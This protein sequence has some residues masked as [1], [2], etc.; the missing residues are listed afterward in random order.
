MGDEQEFRSVKTV[1][2]PDSVAIVGASERGRWPQDI[3]NASV[4]GGYAGDIYLINPRQAEVYGR[5][6]YPTLKDLPKTPDHAIVI[7]P[8]VAVPGVLEDAA[9]V[10]VKSVTV[11]AGAVGDGDSEASHERGRLVREIVRR[12]GIRV[13]GP[14]CMGSFSF[15]EKL[16]AYPNPAVAK[17]PAG[18]VAAIFQ[19]GGTLQFFLATGA[20][21][22][23][24]F[25]Y[26]VSSGNELDL[27]LADYLNFVVDDPH[28]KQ[29]VLF[30][31]GIRRP[32]AFMRAAERALIAGKPIIAIKTGATLKSAQAAA[33]HTGAV[34]GDYSGYLAM[35]ERYGIINCQELDQLVETTLAFQTG[36][37]P[38]GPRVGWITTSGGTVDLLYDDV[39]REGSVLPTFEE[40]TNEALKP[41]MQEGIKP[42]NPLDTGIP[43]NLTDAANVCRVVMNDPNVDMIAWAGQLPANLDRWKGVEDMKAMTQE[44]DKPIVG[45]SRMA[46]PLSKFALE[47]QDQAG[48]PFLQGLPQSCRALN[49]L[50]FHAERSGKPVAAPQPAPFTEINEENLLQ[51]LASRGV[52]GPASAFAPTQEDAMRAAAA[53]GFPVALKIVSPQILHKTEVGG[54]ALGL[55]SQADVKQAAERML[56]SAR[57]AHPDAT[58]EGFLVQEM[59]SGVEVLVGVREDSQF[60]PML[61]LGSGG[62]LVELMADVNVQLL[63]ATRAGIAHAISGLKLQKLL[64]GYRGAPPA[65]AQALYDAIEAVGKFYLDHRGRIADLEINPLIVRPNGQGVCAVDIRTIWKD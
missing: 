12:T 63:P 19:S 7:V 48:F 2:N 32:Q 18:P 6:A 62:V 41:F 53:I 30:I 20:S 60:G 10:G 56:A 61:V 16:F 29:I 27:D 40:T 22:G 3:F 17:T 9:A 25:S 13:A 5:K 37:I 23:L 35:C 65:D 36:R 58:I 26:G 64:D 14:N 15:R 59:A 39:E 49:A 42:K 33:S 57:R 46:Y 8:G 34:A 24:N 28:T 52:K 54:V 21:R 31:E 1:L 38:K 44:T 50:W 11:Y 43:T 45:F 4:E 47:G 55:A 51:A